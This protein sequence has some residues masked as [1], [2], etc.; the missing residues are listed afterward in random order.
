MEKLVEDL[1]VHMHK[2][3]VVKPEDAVTMGKCYMYDYK[4]SIFFFVV[5]FLIT[6]ISCLRPLVASI[7]QVLAAK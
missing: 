2:E 6:L 5:S 1:N 7:K 4:L 3:Y